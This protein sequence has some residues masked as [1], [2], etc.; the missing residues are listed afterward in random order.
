MINVPLEED[1]CKSGYAVL[2]KAIDGTK[3]VARCFDAAC[4][5]A[6]TEMGFL[7]GILSPCLY[8]STECGV[9]VLRHGDDF[10]VLSTRQPQKEFQEHVSK[11]L[12][13]K[14]LATI[15][16]CAALGDFTQV[17]ILSRIVRKV[18][19]PCG[20]GQGVTHNTPS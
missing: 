18:T 19:P 13:V 16:A 10:V 20:A 5:E 17:P 11:H 8:L 2:D 4:E 1:A 9:S 12:I 6:M 7:A 3:D 14:H 15:D